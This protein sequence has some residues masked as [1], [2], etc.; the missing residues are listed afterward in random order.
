MTTLEQ[1]TNLIL[2]LMLSAGYDIEVRLR[3]S[4]MIR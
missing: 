2:V 1:H 3:P 4:L